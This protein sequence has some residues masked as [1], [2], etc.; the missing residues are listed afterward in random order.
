MLFSRGEVYFLPMTS[1]NYREYIH[2]EKGTIH[3]ARKE[4]AS[5]TVFS[6]RGQRVVHHYRITVALRLLRSAYLISTMLLLPKATL[7]TSL[8]YVA[9]TEP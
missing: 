1:L 6:F 4:K 9:Q 7:L 2:G 8:K 3:I 5:A